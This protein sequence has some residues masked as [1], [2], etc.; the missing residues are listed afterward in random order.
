MGDMNAVPRRSGRAPRR[1]LAVSAAFLVAGV[2]VA[3]CSAGSSGQSEGAPV[4]AD[5][6]G[7]SSGSSPGPGNHATQAP[8][9]REDRAVVY[10]AD[11]SVRARDVPAAVA[12]ARKIT[13]DAGGYL[14]DESTTQATRDDPATSRLVLKIPTGKYQ[15]VVDRLGR[16]LGRRLSLR[17]TAQDRTTEVTDVDSRVASAKASLR[18][19][20]TVL[21]KASSVSEILRVED[22]ISSRESDLESL[23][24]RQKSLNRQ[25]SYGTVDLDVTGPRA[26]GHK[27]ADRPGF[28]DGLVHGWYAL[29]TFLRVAVLVIGVL[30][31]FAALA[32]VIAAPI[33]WWLRRRR[34]GGTPPAGRTRPNG[35]NGPNGPVPPAPVPTE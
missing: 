21:D 1:A 17:Q 20:R 11:M 9:T 14:A 34:T 25:T 27:T 23:Q 22:A 15:R 28:W 33:W 8:L 3:G 18:R 32:T 10:T 24:A 29:L 7:R 26:A 31:P 30:L 35:P 12:K 2:V 13:T 5:R 19:L 16:E 6:G 4:K